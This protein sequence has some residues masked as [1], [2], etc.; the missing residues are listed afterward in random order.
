ME[1]ETLERLKD[2][3]SEVEAHLYVEEQVLFPYCS[4]FDEFSTVITRCH[5][6][7]RTA[8]NEL[9]D[10]LQPGTP[11]D[12]IRKFLQ[13][14]RADLEKHFSIEEDELFPRI[15]KQVK[16]SDREELGKQLEAARLE[17]RRGP[18][19]AA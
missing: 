1:A 5:E 11:N 2:L 17:W 4:R 19:K 14:L 12:R 15:R 16:R 9:Q 18:K 8:R 3:K 10:A 7:H 6:E 13:F